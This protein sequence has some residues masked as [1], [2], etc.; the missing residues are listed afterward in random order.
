MKNLMIAVMSGLIFISCTTE[1][2]EACATDSNSVASIIAL[3]KCKAIG[4]S[5]DGEIN[6]DSK[7]PSEGHFEEEK[8][9]T[10]PSLA[11]SAE[12]EKDEISSGE[13]EPSS[14]NTRTNANSSHSGNN[15]RAEN[16]EQ[17]NNN[18]EEMQ[19]DDVSNEKDLSKKSSGR[20]ESRIS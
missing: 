4:D 14:K 1:E 10:E 7:E 17:L 5:V 6:L 20:I 8:D 12:K 9:L 2:W 18:D 15:H 13:N 3:E 11:A 16:K 19:N